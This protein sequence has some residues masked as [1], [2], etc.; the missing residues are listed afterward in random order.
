MNWNKVILILLFQFVVSGT[1][2]Q[3][4]LIEISKEYLT[5]FVKTRN[6]TVS[7][8]EN[9]ALLIHMEARNPLV[10]LFAPEGTWDLSSN[11]SI[12]FEITNLG[13]KP[14]MLNSHIDDYQ[15]NEGV[16]ILNPGEISLMQIL[17]KGY[18][19]PDSHPLARSYEGMH[20][21]PG[22]HY[23]HWVAMDAQHVEKIKLSLINPKES[24]TISLKKIVSEGNL[25]EKDF[26][27]IQQTMFPF[28]DAYGQYMHKDWEGKIHSEEGLKSAM[29]K[30]NR[31]L[32]AYPSPED[33]NQYG[34]WT[35]GKKYKAT[36]HFRVEK[37]D[38]KWW[39]LDPEG[40]LFW[41]HGI[42]GVARAGATTK[43]KGRE[44]YFSQL[45]DKNSPLFQ[46]AKAKNGRILS[47]N[48]TSA[49]LFR[50]YGKKWEPSNREIAHK[51][52]GSWGMNTI[53]NWSDQATYLQ[54]K[55]PYT[56]SVSFPWEKVGGKLKFPNVFATDYKRQLEKVFEKHASTWNDDYCIG[57]FVDN[58]LHGWGKIGM[59]VLM[60]PAKDNA[61]VALV[62]YL[63]DKYQSI[64]Q[65]NRAW[66]SDYRSWEDVLN[67]TS[68]IGEKGARSDLLAFE[69]VMVD[70]YYKTCRD[71][72]KSKAPQKLYLGSRLHNHY[73][74]QDLSHQKWIV[75]IAAKYCD[76]ISFNRYRFVPNDLIFH[77]RKIDKPIIIGEFHFGAL[78]RGMLH[79]GLRSVQNQ[80]QRGRVYYE[81]IKGALENP[82]IVGAHWFQYGEQAVTGRFDGENYQIG[83]LDVCDSPYQ[84]TIEASRK[85]G[86]QLYKIRLNK[87]NT[88]E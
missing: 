1:L 63:T 72:I 3:Q 85:I 80:Q 30:E 59:T 13:D 54:R 75:P 41:S 8:K 50:K 19:L 33:R 18:R 56:V 66:T 77:D 52:L 48:Y 81:Y 24:A 65:L 28:V 38:G 64:E 36:G 74:P 26:K 51:R 69:K 73:Y 9:N 61:K 5:N 76:V 10:E 40:C 16:L 67:S 60:S 87:D 32:E 31:D 34:G 14:I 7:L 39:M 83:F 6:A 57:Y 12:S 88:K 62:N 44:H 49:N 27:E 20:G 47:Y 45:P 43:V 23:K 78:D 25:L 35:K 70:L 22:G 21:Y 68:G 86:Y 58:E 2:A 46:F 37:I 17:I 71:V 79:T 4:Q 84:E 29:V 53:G 55:T 11:S 42:T 15:F 82:Y